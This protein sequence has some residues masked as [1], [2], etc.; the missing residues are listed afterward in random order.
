MI[1][2]QVDIEIHNENIY[3]DYLHWLDLHI[4]EMLKVR[5][6]RECSLLKY[7]LTNQKQL[8]SVRY[9]VEN[10]ESLEEY[11]QLHSQK[12]RSEG[13]TKFHNEV[14]YERHILELKKSWH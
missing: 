11:L 8:L 13:I 14:T 1:I 6:F 10:R 2:Y 4:L 3:E 7:E 9:N 5:G 12:M